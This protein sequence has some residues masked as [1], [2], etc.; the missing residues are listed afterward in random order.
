MEGL[1]AR[2]VTDA[3]RGLQKCDDDGRRRLAALSG[4]Q[5][6]SACVVA[7]LRPRP[8]PDEYWVTDH[9]CACVG[10]LCGEDVNVLLA[11]YPTPCDCGRWFFYDGTAVLSLVQPMA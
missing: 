8:V 7:G 10:C 1:A 6:V 5:W 9:D 11:A 2:D 4:F 3:A